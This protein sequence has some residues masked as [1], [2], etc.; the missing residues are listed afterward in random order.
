M[1]RRAV[2][3]VR[4]RPALQLP[5]LPPTR[6]FPFDDDRQARAFAKSVRE[7]GDAAEICYKVA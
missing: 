4:Y 6:D 1:N 5:H 2:V 3:T 7:D